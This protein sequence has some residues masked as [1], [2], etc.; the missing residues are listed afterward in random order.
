MAPLQADVTRVRI[1]RRR[2]EELKVWAPEAMTPIFTRMQNTLT[3]ISQAGAPSRPFVTL[4]EEP[5]GTW[6]VSRFAAHNRP[7]I[8]L[9]WPAGAKPELISWLRTHMRNGV[10]ATTRP[11]VPS[12]QL[13]FS[14]DG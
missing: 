11:D 6:K 3:A 14:C 2:L 7:W 9:E 13:W 12:N 8:G 1:L 10:L 5:N 4:I